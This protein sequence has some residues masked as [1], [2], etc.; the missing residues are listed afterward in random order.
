LDATVALGCYEDELRLAILRMKRQSGRPLALAM[1]RL[2]AS[3]C[4]QQIAD[5]APTLIVPVPPYWLHYL[6]RG[7]NSPDVLADCLRHDLRIPVSQRA[8]VRCRNT[9]PQ[10][11]LSPNE[12]F[13]NMRGAFRCRPRFPIQGA[14]VLLVD[15]VLTSGATCSAMATTLKKGGAS[16]VGAAVLARTKLE[17][18]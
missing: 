10:N 2:L 5:L 3:Q 13:A 9:L 7:F 6:W 12:R 11:N 4:K 1:G 18:S 17:H 14:R 16:W 8:V 15:D